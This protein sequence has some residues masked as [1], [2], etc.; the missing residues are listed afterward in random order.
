MI[1]LEANLILVRIKEIFSVPIRIIKGKSVI[2]SIIMI[3]RLRTI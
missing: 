1:R 2:W 3:R